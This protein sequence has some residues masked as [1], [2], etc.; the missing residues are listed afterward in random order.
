MGLVWTDPPGRPYRPK[1]LLLSKSCKIHSTAVQEIGRYIDRLYLLRRPE[2]IVLSPAVAGE[3]Q[4]SLDSGVGRGLD[5][6]IAVAHEIGPGEVQVQVPGRLLNQG[7]FGLAAGAALLRA[8]EAGI[9]AVQVGAP[10]R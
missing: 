3:H 5:I 6:L 7:G 9:D 8:V 4:D 10:G 1:S 2:I